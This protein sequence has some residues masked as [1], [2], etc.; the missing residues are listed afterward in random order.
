MPDFGVVCLGVEITEVYCATG[1][2]L[3]CYY[4]HVAMLPHIPREIGVRLKT[5]SNCRQARPAYVE[6]KTQCARKRP[7]A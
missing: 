4:I 3:D 1:V 7:D 2:R 6:M 5:L